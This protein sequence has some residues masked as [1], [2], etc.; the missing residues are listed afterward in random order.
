MDLGLI[1]GHGENGFNVLKCVLKI[2]SCNVCLNENN[3]QVCGWT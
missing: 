3:E 1:C 2:F